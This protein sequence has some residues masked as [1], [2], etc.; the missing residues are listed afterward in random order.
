MVVLWPAT[1]ETELWLSVIAPP[2]APAATVVV[3][4]LQVPP[5]AQIL[6]LEEPELFPIKV[7]VL[8]LMFA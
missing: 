7:S 6:I 1:R 8:L 4:E 3:K 5:K 2:E